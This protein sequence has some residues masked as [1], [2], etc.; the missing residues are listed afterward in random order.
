MSHLWVFSNSGRT[1][2]CTKCGSSF[3]REIVDRETWEL[4][5]TEE[6]R[7]KV[8]IPEDCDEMMVR[9]VMES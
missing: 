5:D 2:S 8:G 7:K 1:C 4:Q 3:H 9:Q 6:A